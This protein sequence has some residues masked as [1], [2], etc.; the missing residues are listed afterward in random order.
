MNRQRGTI[1]TLRKNILEGKDLKEKVLEM[2]EQ[3]ISAY[4]DLYFPKNMSAEDWD[5]GGFIGAIN[6]IIPVLNLN[7]ITELKNR[8]AIKE[9]IIKLFEGAYQSRE[10]E[11][12]HEA[13]RELEKIV[14]LKIIDQKWIDQL[15]N[16]DN[17]REG[18]GLRGYAG[19]DP[20]LEYK[21]EGYKMFKEMMVMAKQEIVSLI[22]RVEIAKGEELLPKKKAV[23]FG[24]PKSVS[25]PNPVT[26]KIK[27]G[28]NDP[29]PC[30]SGKKYKKCC[31]GKT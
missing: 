25:R 1:Y 15:H 27:I 8:D 10:K 11:I 31:L 9:T 5:F 13:M 7:K 6:E 24:E 19:K 28:R 14:M 16:M 4:I 21:I 26:H 17:L 22:L 23:V 20:L 3:V 29:C 30:G 12:G 18:I 2:I